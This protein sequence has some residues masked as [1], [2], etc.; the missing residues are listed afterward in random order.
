MIIY[1]SKNKILIGSVFNNKNECYPQVFS[2]EYC[3]ECKKCYDILIM[4]VTSRNKSKDEK[5]KQY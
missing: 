2:E 4:N 5:M 3:Y 1:P